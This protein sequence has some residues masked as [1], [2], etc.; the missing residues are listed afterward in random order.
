MID[1]APELTFSRFRMLWWN[2]EH[3]YATLDFSSGP[4]P[5]TPP[6]DDKKT[7]TVK[8]EEEDQKQF[9]FLSDPFDLGCSRI[10]PVPNHH[11][12]HLNLP[13]AGSSMHRDEVI[14]RKAS[15]LAPKSPNVEWR[16]LPK[17]PCDQRRPAKTAPLKPQI[18]PKPTN[19]VNPRMVTS[20]PTR[21]V[22]MDVIN[23]EAVVKARQIYA[24]GQQQQPTLRQSLSI[25]SFADLMGEKKKKFRFVRKVATSFRFKKPEKEPVVEK[26]VSAPVNISRSL[27]QSPHVERKLKKPACLASSEKATNAFSWLPSRSPKR[28]HKTTPENVQGVVSPTDT[29]ETLAEKN[30]G[31]PL[32]LA[33]CV[34]FIEKM[35]HEVSEVSG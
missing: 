19:I 9:S 25:E 6:K 8:K 23:R 31:I 16:W 18:A 28:T 20:M 14:E 5:A 34:E 32:F 11:H 12:R 10:T 13:Q 30:D 3:I 4:Q 2:D 29:L 7:S 27:P 1:I 17:S 21:S 33:R 24:R 15:S 22:T 35:I 26:L